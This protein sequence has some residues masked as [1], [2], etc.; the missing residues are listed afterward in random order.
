MKIKITSDSTCD[1]SSELAER[2][3]VGIVPLYIIKDGQEFVDGVSIT[4][5]DIFEHVS[6]GG[7]ICTSAARSSLVYREEFNKY[8]NDYDGILHISL[9]SGFS[10]S[11]QNACIAAKE[12][13]NVRV[14]DSQ[15]LAHARAILF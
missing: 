13:H 3:N 4:P 8:T 6:N 10:S 15:N 1:L 11:Y 2:L 5:A 14:L 7:N 12:F 9:G